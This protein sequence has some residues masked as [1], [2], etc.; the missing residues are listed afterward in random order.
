MSSKIIEC[1][2]TGVDVEAAAPIDLLL[3]KST[4]EVHHVQCRIGVDKKSGRVKWCPD[5]Q[6][7]KYLLVLPIILMPVIVFFVLMMRISNT[8]TGRIEIYPP[9]ERIQ[10]STELEAFHRPTRDVNELLTTIN[11]NCELLRHLAVEKSIDMYDKELFHDIRT[12][13]IPSELCHY[14]NATNNE[15][16]SFDQSMNSV[17]DPQQTNQ[18]KNVDQLR[19]FINKYT[20]SIDFNRLNT[21]YGSIHFRRRRRR[22]IDKT[23][24]FLNG[25]NQV[26]ASIKNISY[27][28]DEPADDK[29]LEIP[30]FLRTFW[31]GGKTYDQIRNSQVEII[32]QYM[33]ASVEPCDDFYQYACGNWD[34]LNPIPKDKAAYDTFE[35]LREILDIELNSL[36]SDS[37]ATGSNTENV[38]DINTTEYP[39]NERSDSL[40]SIEKNMIKRS[41]NAQNFKENESILNAEI[42]A[43][44]LYQSC[45]NSI[46]L[47]ARKLEPL[48]EL[49]NSLGGWP[50][51]D[52]DK[53]DASKFNWLELAAKL[54]L[55][56]NDVFLMQWVGPDI[57]HSHEN[58]IQ[59]DQ[60]SL[61]LPT[62]D[63][64][65]KSTNIVYLEAY[66][67]FAKQ[68]IFLCGANEND[69]SKTADEIVKFEIELAKIM[70]SP[71]DRMNV[72]QLYRRMTIASLYDYVP[73]IDWQRYLEIVLEQKIDRNEMVVM[74]A[75]NFMQDVVMLID[76]TEPRIVANYMLWKFVRHRINSLD[77]RFQDAKQQF[78]NVLIGRKKSPPRWKT[79]V[80]QVNSNMGM[81]VGAM[82]VREY[83]D[84]S[85]KQ[86]TLAMTHELQDTFREILNETLWLDDETKA[87]AE[88]KVNRMSL[89]IGYPDYILDREKLN[90]KY[91]DLDIHP[92]KYFENVLNVLRHLTRSEQGKLREAVNRTAWNTAPAVVNAYYSRNKN[93][94][95]FPAAILQPPFYHRYL[96]RSFNFG[97]IGFLFLHFLILSTFKIILNIY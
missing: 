95:I 57:K 67:E 8:F 44:Y 15:I 29:P 30:A 75:L 27:A 18:S 4:P 43:K 87:L 13:F 56:N 52:G 10:M 34:K 72:T 32:K 2:V 28:D 81:A 31:Q 84:D 73:E 82:F 5:C 64:F 79:C 21:E 17:Y 41:Q 91:A 85:S 93:Q 53:W 23:I 74:F 40:N 80:N 71:Q 48:N 78:Y 89:K 69:S 20:D 3:P 88:S 94:I 16:E 39:S 47:E 25:T 97:G 70:A 61:G 77:D 86:D 11:H 9:T 62:R 49:L 65:I 76:N 83:F 37:K 22:Q 96:P 7:I 60:N 26:D 54:R 42:K 58:V 45:M 92:D 38:V 12:S 33:D 66:Q 68:V 59:F 55:Y 51:L 63:Y 19:R 1:D 46:I 36:L 35:M 6:F 24:E 50:V 90:E 14:E